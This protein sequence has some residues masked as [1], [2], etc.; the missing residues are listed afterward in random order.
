MTRKSD[1]NQLEPGN[2]F[3]LSPKM[4]QLDILHFMTWDERQMSTL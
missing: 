2:G 1:K 4:Y 3:G